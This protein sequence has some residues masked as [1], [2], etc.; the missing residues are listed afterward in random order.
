MRSVTDALDDMDCVEFLRGQAWL[1]EQMAA[2]E[3][4]EAAR[5]SAML[6]VKKWR[7]AAAEIERLRVLQNNKGAHRSAKWLGY[8]EPNSRG[9]MQDLG[10]SVAT[11]AQ[12]TLTADE[13]L[14]VYQ[15]LARF[16]ALEDYG[17]ARDW[18]GIEAYCPIMDGATNI[19]GQT[20][21]VEIRTDGT[22]PNTE[23]QTRP[24][25]T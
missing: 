17:Y 10:Q 14:I 19:Q 22:L 5:V 24:P 1:T 20:P 16:H 9:L 8:N 3:T 25:I 11:G 21:E 2:E 13:A 12:Y 15:A 4:S 7:E 18:E 6:R 23:G